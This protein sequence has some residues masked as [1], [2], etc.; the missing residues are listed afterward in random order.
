MPLKGRNKQWVLR[1]PD[2]LLARELSRGLKINPLLARL[3]INRN[4]ES[5]SA[6]RVFLWG[7]LADLHNPFLLKGMQEAVE[8]VVESIARGHRICV[9]GDYDVDGITSAALLLRVLRRLQADARVYLP[10]R[11]QEGYSLR[12]PALDELAK[13]GVKLIITVDC[14]ITSCLEVEHAAELGMQVIISDHHQLGEQLPR[15]AAV[16]NPQ[17]PDCPYPF[18][19]LAGVGVALKLAQGLLAQAGF[20]HEAAALPHHELDL[21]ALGTVADVV[22]LTG[23]NRILVKYGLK[24]LTKSRK[25]G[26]KALCKIVGLEAEQPITAADVGFKL[27]PRLNAAGRLGGALRGL[28]LL[29]ST[30]DGES[31]SLARELEEQNRQRRLIE[32]KILAQAR[33]RLA[34]DRAVGLPKVIVLAGEGWH[35]GVI[36]IVASRLQEEFYRPA[37]VIAV[38]DGIGKGSGR[39]I[40]NFHLQRALSRC[41]ELLLEFGGHAMA[42]GLS[43]E[44]EKIPALRARMNELADDLLREDDLSPL[45]LPDGEIALEDL[46]LPLCRELQQMSPF[47]MGNPAPVFCARRVQLLGPPRTVGNNH[48]KLKLRQGSCVMDGI[49]FNMGDLCEALQEQ[50]TRGLDVLFRPRLNTWQGQEQLQLQLRDIALS[51]DSCQ[52]LSKALGPA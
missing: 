12:R 43:I 52:S 23:E 48:L 15:A 36:G 10:N 2:P 34:A 3:L 46:D 6:A 18:K 7:T 4:I 14:G 22:P 30:R 47:G 9:Y 32:D 20:L 39:S 24:Q 37:I 42:A 41:R 21:V 27:A 28:R 44:Q 26:I 29:L 45:S 1:R 13:D 8:L 38:Q 5:L 11:L 31:V 25:S 50:G 49:G 33:A 16:I 19:E 51:E 35:A 17:Q 40:P